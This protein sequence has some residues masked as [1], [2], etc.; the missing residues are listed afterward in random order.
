[1][2]LAR[3]DV[4]QKINEYKGFLDSTLRPQLEEANAAKKVVVEE[5][6]EYEYLLHHLKKAHGLSTM[7]VDL[8]YEKAY[9][10]ATI[11]P[12]TNVF[13]DVGMGFH[14]EFTVVEALAFCEKRM[15]FLRGKLAARK[16]KLGKIEDHVTTAEDILEHLAN[17]A[18]SLP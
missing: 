16:V 4:E 12:N 8:G 7:T 13:V 15:R 14:V 17:E 6:K 10:E 9:C 3:S 2:N 11:Q 5:I 18:S 1:M